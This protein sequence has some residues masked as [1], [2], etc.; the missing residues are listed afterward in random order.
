MMRSFTQTTNLVSVGIAF[1]TISAYLATI[2]LAAEEQFEEILF[3]SEGS[4]HR[5][6]IH[7]RNLLSR[8]DDAGGVDKDKKL[9]QMTSLL[10]TRLLKPKKKDKKKPDKKNLNKNNKPNKDKIAQ[11][12]KRKDRSNKKNGTGGKDKWDGFGKKEWGGWDGNVWNDCICDGGEWWRGRLLS[13]G[14]SEES[15]VSRDEDEEDE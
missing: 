11:K 14:E 2:A 12:D 5:L 8:N 7:R 15:T 6:P 1:L 9:N 3:S 4:R 13:D 10:Q